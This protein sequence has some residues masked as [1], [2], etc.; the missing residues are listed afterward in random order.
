MRAFVASFFDEC[1]LKHVGGSFL[2]KQLETRLPDRIRYA[3]YADPVTGKRFDPHADDLAAL[4]TS[5]L[6][7]AYGGTKTG[8]APATY[9]RDLQAA[10]WNRREQRIDEYVGHHRRLYLQYAAARGWTPAEE[11]ANTW[12]FCIKT[13]VAHLDPILVADFDLDEECSFAEARLRL[14]RRVTYLAAK[15]DP[16]M[17]GACVAGVNNADRSASDLPHRTEEK[18][19]KKKNHSEPAITAPPAK[20]PRANSG[21]DNGPC[22]WGLKCRSAQCARPHPAGWDAAAA[23]AAFRARGAD[24]RAHAPVAVSAA[25]VTGG[26]AAPPILEDMLSPD[27]RCIIHSTPPTHLNKACRDSRHPRH[28]YVRKD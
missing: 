3:V 10:R 8:D 18:K 27:S 9:L 19:E 25:A 4:I 13:M 24:G 15:G 22:R 14:L 21:A 26:Q 7:C 2:Q 5:A 16:Y 20:K 12:H 11:E 6:L 23:L 1:A 17:K 28:L